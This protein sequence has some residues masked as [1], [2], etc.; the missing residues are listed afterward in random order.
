MHGYGGDALVSLRGGGA[1]HFSSAWVSLLF[2]FVLF[3][4]VVW[5][6]TAFGHPY[7]ALILDIV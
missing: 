4:F 7:L 5:E 1:L 6:L 3:G 2:P